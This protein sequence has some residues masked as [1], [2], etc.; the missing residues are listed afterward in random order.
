M[1][2]IY[3]P[4]LID[5]VKI[6]WRRVQG[7]RRMTLIATMDSEGTMQRIPPDQQSERVEAGAVD[8]LPFPNDEGLTHLLN[9]V[10]HASLL[11]EE[12][13][14]L[15]LRVAYLPPDIL[16]DVH[17]PHLN[18][19]TQPFR[20]NPP[21]VLTPAELMRLG[22]ATDPTRALVLVAD[23]RAFRIDH[24]SPLA[25]WGV[26]HLGSD[27]WELVTG[28][29]SGATCPPN[30]FTVSSHGPGELV[31]SAGGSVLSDYVPAGWSCPRWKAS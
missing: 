15:G 17:V 31:I 26:L 28:R 2:F 3:P 10:Y 9:T 16:A 6:A 22:P 20:L 8:T 11:A 29:A 7:P 12:N 25:I 4:T 27:W 24:P 5:E 23:S 30:T 13:R 19:D 21:R 14:R 18:V 1:E